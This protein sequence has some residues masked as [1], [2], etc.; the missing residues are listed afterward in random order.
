MGSGSPTPLRAFVR[1]TFGK[2]VGHFASGVAIL[3]P[4]AQESTP[5][6]NRSQ[7]EPRRPNGYP[8]QSARHN[9]DRTGHKRERKDDPPGW[10]SE[11]RPRGLHLTLAPSQDHDGGDRKDEVEDVQESS[12]SCGEDDR[13][14]KGYERNQKPVEK[15][16]SPRRGARCANRREG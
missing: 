9:E 8:N 2:S 14:E 13:F 12:D 15:D 4:P 6:E 11:R 7:S 10:H 5:P 3:E 16:R 1:G